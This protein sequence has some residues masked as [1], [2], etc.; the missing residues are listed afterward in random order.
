M[1][2]VLI[3]GCGNMA[4]GFDASRPDTPTPFSHAGAYRAHGGFALRACVDPDRE[5]REAFQLRWQ[6][7]AGY[8]SLRSIA[9]QGMHFDV[10]S[11][12]SPTAFHADDLRWA[13]KMKPRLVFCEKPL[14]AKL[15]DSL[16]LASQY[17]QANLPLMLNYTRRFD[18]RVRELARQLRQGE[19]GNIRSVSATYN[20]GL[21]NNGSH[22]LDLLAMLLG[23]LQLVAAGAPIID[24]WP[25]DPS[26]PALLQNRDGVPITLNCGHAGDY[27]LFELELV[28]Q[29]GTVKMENGGLDWQ[30]RRAGPSATFA[31]Y[32]SLGP[33]H[34]QP[35][36]LGYAA[37]TAVT[38]I[39]TVLNH[40]QT[41]SC[42]AEHGVA[43]QVL[44]ESIRTQSLTN[45]LP[46]EKT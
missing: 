26:I 6:V 2:D 14:T 18:P 36:S 12:C 35:G 31:G 9:E 16:T 23:P 21:Y 33:A 10:I 30:E 17:R 32:Q 40:G 1:L 43:V 44:C 5:K 3:V 22:M 20:K 37:L 13:L 41:P 7:D 24:M 27:S 34:H 11:I 38:E 39:E 46:S 8:D 29:H 15:Q 4:G 25:E 45:N 28:T 19:W 42:H